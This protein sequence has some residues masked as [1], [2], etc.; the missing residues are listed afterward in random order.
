M[1]ASITHDL[2]L[3]QPPERV[4]QALT[5]P[6][7]LAQWL[8][9]NDFEP[10]VG[11]R[12]TFQADAMPALD[13]DGICH[14]EVTVCEPPYLLAYTWNGGA[15]RTLVTFRLEREGSGTHLYF[16]HSGFELDDPRQQAGYRGMSGGWAPKLDT[17]LRAVVAEQV[18]T[19]G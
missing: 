3:P 9:P 15:L 11:H 7:Q 14:C 4:W 12:F 17:R 10:G 16:E 5:D 8:M 6:A 1:T 18:A 2:S 19:R 13:F